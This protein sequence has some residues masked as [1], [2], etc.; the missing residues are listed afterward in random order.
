MKRTVWL[1]ALAL[2]VLFLTAGCGTLMEE[3]VVRGGVGELL[4]GVTSN[5][6]QETTDEEGH[7]RRLYSFTYEGVTF[8]LDNYQYRESLFGTTAAAT[9]NTYA[10]ALYE[11]YAEELQAIAERNRVE[12]GED[13]LS[14]FCSGEEL[15]I[16][17]NSEI[18]R[19]H[20]GASYYYWISLD[21]FALLMGMRVERV[22]DQAVFLAVEKQ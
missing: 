18:D 20:A 13:G 16:E 14:F 1:A 11:A 10:K 22:T 19:Q 15:P 12:R 4:P 6:M 3:S 5:G 8:T 2:T 17:A 7:G 21:D 9:S